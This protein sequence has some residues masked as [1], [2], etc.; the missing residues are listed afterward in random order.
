M[1]RCCSAL[2]LAGYL[3]AWLAFG[4]CA[5][6]LG[7][8]LLA[9]VPPLALAD[10]QRLADRRRRSCCW[11]GCSS[12]RRS[13]IAAWTR[14]ARRCPSCSAAGTACGR[15]STASGSAS[16]TGVYC[17]GCCWALMLL[18][19]VV[20]TGSIG[21][22]LVLGAADGAGEEQPWGR[23]LAA[24]VGVALIAVASADRAGSDCEALLA[25]LC[26]RPTRRRSP[27]AAPW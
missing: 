8:G 10:L 12:S 22:M 3:A 18:M 27:R 11:P 23:A 21:W 17:V 7:L 13:S 26:W 19:F 16:R 1:R 20:G 9:L 14:A 25:K 4:L 6:L 2:L 5:H 24:P 15:G